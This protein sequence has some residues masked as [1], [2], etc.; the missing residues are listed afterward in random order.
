MTALAGGRCEVWGTGTAECSPCTWLLPVQLGLRNQ[1]FQMR[2]SKCGQVQRS[3]PG[4]GR[5]VSCTHPL[6]RGV[7]LQLA[8]GQDVLPQACSEPQWLLWA[9]CPPRHSAWRRPAVKTRLD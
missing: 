1:M 3:E 9:V 6:H 2:V 7:Q 4:G 8:G 5:C